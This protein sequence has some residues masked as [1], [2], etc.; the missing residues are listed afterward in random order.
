MNLITKMVSPTKHIN[1]LLRRRVLLRLPLRLL[2]G[3]SLAGLLGAC[4][5]FSA[6]T[7]PQPAE[8][9][10]LSTKSVLTPLWTVSLSSAGVGF[11]PV[12]AGDSVIAAAADGTVIRVAAKTG[13]VVWRQS[14]PQDLVAGVGSDGETAVVAARDGSLIALD[15]T[16]KTRWSV[17]LGVEVVTVPAVGEGM[18][19][20]RGS[21]N[22]ISA[23]ELESGKRRWTLQRQAPTL[24]LRQTGAINIDGSTVYAGLPGGRMLAMNAQNGAVRWEVAVT[25]ARGSNEIERIADVVALPVVNGRDVCAAS[26]QGRLACFETSTGRGLWVRD[27]SSVAGLDLDSAAAYVVDDKDQVHA[28][29]RSGASLWRND[30]FSF[31]GLTRPLA[32]GP[33][34]VVGDASGF[35]HAVT[36]EDGAVAG[37]IATDGSAIL[38]GPILVDGILVVQTSAGSLAGFSAQ[39]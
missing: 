34:V 17:A 4:S 22:R 9:V 38:A 29:S 31:R 37:R 33:F 27:M 20:V 35:V 11:R 8:L 36:R 10:T 30:K 25:Q 3:L 2:T 14:L 6:S 32:S 12:A 24:M 39:P 28:Y 1:A 23:F 19:V 21:D 15:S 7:K 18:V 26:F 13:K 16:G 5:W